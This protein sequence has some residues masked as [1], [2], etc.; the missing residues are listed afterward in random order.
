MVVHLSIVNSYILKPDVTGDFRDA[1]FILFLKVTEFW[2]FLILQGSWFQIM[3][4]RVSVCR[5][6][7]S[8]SDILTYRELTCLIWEQ[9]VLPTV[10]RVKNH[11]DKNLVSFY[12]LVC[13]YQLHLCCS[14]SHRSGVA[15]LVL[16][17]R[18][19][20]LLACKGGSRSNNYGRIRMVRV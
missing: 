19:H 16:A 4:L 2:M 13:K 11:L 1:P 18:D 10:G 6:P 9:V 3:G 15:T 20:A 12:E 7:I 8:V 5:A 17:R 14:P